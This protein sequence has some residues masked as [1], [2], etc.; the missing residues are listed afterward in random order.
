MLALVGHTAEIPTHRQIRHEPDPSAT[1]GRDD[2]G[3]VNLQSGDVLFHDGDPRTVAFRVVSGGLCHHMSWPDGHH[4]VIE[5]AFPGDIIGFGHLPR[6]VSTAQA[7]AETVVAELN[8]GELERAIASDAQLAA[9]VYDFADR[10]FEIARKR[11]A[12]QP[13]SPLSRIAAFVRALQAEAEREGRHTFTLDSRALTADI[14]VLMQIP[15][16]TAES[17]VSELMQRGALTAHEAGLTV[18]DQRTL[19]ELADCG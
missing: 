14:A 3:V 7:L 2:R 6:R 18:A 11:A 9:R 19:E 1:S 8:A 13:A 5:F 16:E 15:E 17:A 12:H 10:E 4:D